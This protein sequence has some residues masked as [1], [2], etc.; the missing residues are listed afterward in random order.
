MFDPKCT[1]PYGF[2]CINTT[3]GHLLLSLEGKLQYWYIHIFT[4]IKVGAPREEIE[5]FKSFFF[6]P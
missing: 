2:I 1:E 5:F 4:G 6:K 3:E